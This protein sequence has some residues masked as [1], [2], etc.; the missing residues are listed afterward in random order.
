MYTLQRTF[1]ADTQPFS[2]VSSEIAL[3]H[4]HTQYG[5][6][7]TVVAPEPQASTVHAQIGWME[8]TEHA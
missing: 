1:F 8:Y 4:A 2:P 6:N 7:T 5:S 3:V